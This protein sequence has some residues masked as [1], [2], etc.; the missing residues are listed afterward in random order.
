M[1]RPL[2]SYLIAAF[3]S[4]ISISAAAAESQ[5]PRQCNG[6]PRLNV[7]TAPGFCLGLVADKIKAP[8]GLLPLPNGDIFVADMGS[9]EPGRGRIWLLRRAAGGFQKT[10]IFD[11]LDRPNSVALGP[12]GKI[13]VGMPG[14]IERFAP[15]EAKPAL[16]DVVGGV[17]G[18]EALPGKG[19]HLLPA[20]LF[21]AKG[22]LFVSVGSASDHCENAE[23][24]MPQGPTC[25]ERSGPD[26]LGV[27]RKYAMRW[28][29]GKVRGWDVHARGLRNSMAMAVDPRTQIL[30]QGENARDSIHA[31][32]PELK[33]DNELPHDE[34]NAILPGA[35]YGWPYCYDNALPSPEY[36]TAQ[37][38]GF[39][40][41]IRLLPAHAA[42]LGMAF[43][44]GKQFPA[45]LQHSLIVAYHGY[46]KHGHR[47]VAL[48]D[49]G[50]KG[51]VGRSLTLVTGARSQANG[52]GAPVGIGIGADGSA[53]ISDDHAGIVAQLYYEG[54]GASPDSLQP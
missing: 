11:R 31:A 50:R 2:S 20:I 15:G 5:S 4:L 39:R 51:P 25:S 44:T 22:N 46:R 49:Q 1:S 26:G 24:A 42:P 17:S 7:A 40:S 38:R 45:V 33:N 36:P 19:R 12:D 30:W 29:E 23:G 8:R 21:D 13:Y 34:L 47:V 41:P 37:C 27:I 35:D 43:Y 9:W 28:P 3:A 14:R 53:Y 48:L 52:M 6:L 16:F 32:M 54:P 10:V 18:V